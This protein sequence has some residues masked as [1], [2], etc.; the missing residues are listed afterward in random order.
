MWRELLVNTI[1]VTSALSLSL[2]NPFALQ[3]AP[4]AALTNLATSA[5]ASAPPRPV[6]H[7]AD[8]RK[9]QQK[10]EQL[11]QSEKLLAGDDDTDGNLSVEGADDGD[12]EAAPTLL[13]KKIGKI[14]RKIRFFSTLANASGGN[15]GH[16]DG[17]VDETGSSLSNTTIQTTTEGNT[18]LNDT[19]D[20]TPDI[21]ENDVRTSEEI[22]TERTRTFQK[23]IYPHS[24]HD[25]P[26]KVSFDVNEKIVNRPDTEDVAEH[27]QNIQMVEDMSRLG[28]IGV[29]F[30]EIV[31]SIVGLIYGA[32]AHITSNTNGGKHLE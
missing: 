14:L 22:T 32:A 12:N 20:G 28:Q 24:K 29:F 6:S 17:N 30:A 8:L 25:A 21:S 9:K 23:V 19:L 15:G 7:I 13:Q 5:S 10:V 16:G 26:F 4:T 3:N 31:G 1:F 18:N 2:V 27:S 11:S